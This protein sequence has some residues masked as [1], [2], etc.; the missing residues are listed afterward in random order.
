MELD[1]RKLWEGKE[2]AQ[3]A[4]E[5]LDGIWEVEAKNIQDLNGKPVVLSEVELGLI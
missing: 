1:I 5:G 3:P 4:S 2:G